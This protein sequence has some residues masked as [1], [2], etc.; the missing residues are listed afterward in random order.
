MLVY[1]ATGAIVYLGMALSRLTGESF[2][3]RDR[4][5]FDRLLLVGLATPQ[6]VFAIAI[7]FAMVEPRAVTLGVGIFSGLGWTT[8]SWIT[9]HWIGYFHAVVRT[10][11]VLAGWLL[12]PAHHFQVVPAII[13]LMYAITIPVLEQ[14]WRR[15]GA[16]AGT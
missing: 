6:L 5:A 11:L 1:L 8:F 4:N 7:P 14:R 12:F 2:F 15:S 3:R 10:L 9:Q 16:A 13:V